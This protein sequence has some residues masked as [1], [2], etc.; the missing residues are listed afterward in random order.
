M[1]IH[2]TEPLS[3]EAQGF[4]SL[5]NLNAGGAAFYLYQSWERPKRHNMRIERAAMWYTL[6]LDRDCGRALTSPDTS[7]LMPPGTDVQ[8]RYELQ[9]GINT[10]RHCLP[11]T[12]SEREI[13]RSPL[14]Q[15]VED[16]EF[17]GGEIV[18]REP[19]L[20]DR[21]HQW[22]WMGQHGEPQTSIEALGASAVLA[23]GCKRLSGV[24]PEVLGWEA[25]G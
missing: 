1:A 15:M 7:L 21:W 3:V 23:E 24:L 5:M 18:A 17:I 10:V 8:T 20:A 25:V 4:Y 13:L 19:A 2:E 14:N 6:M 11:W 16:Y 12:H 22:L 9:A